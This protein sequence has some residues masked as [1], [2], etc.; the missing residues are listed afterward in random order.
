[1]ARLQEQRRGCT[2][3]QLD[4][5]LH[6]AA[7]L[8]TLIQ[9]ATTESCNPLTFN[10]AMNSALADEWQDACQYEIDALNRNR[11]WV[12]VEL[13]LGWKAVKS[14]WVFKH[15]VDG[16]FHARLVAKGFMQTFRIDYDETFSPVAQFKSL[17][18][19]L[20]LAMLEDWEIH[21]MDVKL[22][23][24][25]G[26]LDEEI[27]MEQPQGSIDPDNPNKVCLLKK[28]IYGL[29][30]ASHAWNLQFHGVLL[31]LGF[32]CTHSDAGIYHR[33]DHGGMLI[34]ILYVDNITTFGDNLDS[35]NNLKAKLSNCYEMTDLGEINSYLGVRI[36]RDRSTKRLEI[37]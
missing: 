27:Y 2:C 35:V 15:K 11:T 30:Q 20:A 36:K 26:L 22:A 33:Q 18:L 10:E 1:M 6:H 14:K 25:N 34:I 31:D 23:F 5:K 3:A 8:N 24:L 19:L 16:H 12:L 29:K 17:R 9:V 13:P 37:D 28:A 4:G 21:Q 32:A 7:L